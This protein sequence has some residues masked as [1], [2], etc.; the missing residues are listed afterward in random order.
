MATSRRP[1]ARAR[2][3]VEDDLR[4]VLAEIDLAR[5]AAGLSHDA[6]AETCRVSGSTI[7]R[8]LAGDI[9]SPDLRLLAAMS[10][11][12]GQ[13]L[14]LRSFLSGDPIRDAGQ[15]RLLERFHARV[16][17][18][19]RWRTEVP[20][21]I[22]GDLRAWDAV[23]SGPG[24]IAAIEAETVLEDVQAVERRVALKRRDGAMD[25]VLLVVSDAARN[26]RALGSAPGAFP[27]FDR[28]ARATLRALAAGV[29]PRRSAILLL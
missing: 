28:A 14:R 1:V 25:R 26:R 15:Q 9:A 8:T 16:S 5:R 13:E 23:I 22:A 2:R 20:L 3:R 6:I 10:A 17:P 4:R 11:A 24:W 21:P 27:D 12:V 7:A 18:R 19:T 29:D